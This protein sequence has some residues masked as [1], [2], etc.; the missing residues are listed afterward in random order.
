[1]SN[2]NKDLGKWILRDVLNIPIGTV[3]NYSLLLN[4]GIDSVYVEKWSDGRNVYY[5]IFPATVGEYDRYIRGSSI[6]R[7]PV[8]NTTVQPIKTI[9]SIESVVKKGSSI[10]HPKF[11]KEL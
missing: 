2:P 9:E 1:M 6:N 5:K 4:R 3:V 7:K 10:V 8:T 11:E